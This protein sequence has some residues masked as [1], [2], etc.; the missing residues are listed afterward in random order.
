MI[1]IPATIAS[2]AKPVVTVEES[3]TLR[4]GKSPV[5]IN[6]RPSKSI[7][8]SLPA[9][10]F[11]A[12]MFLLLKSN[13]KL[14]NLV[15]YWFEEIEHGAQDKS[16]LMKEDR[17]GSRPYGTYKSYILDCLLLLPSASCLLP[18]AVRL[19]PSVIQSQLLMLGQRLWRSWL[20]SRHRSMGKCSSRRE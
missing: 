15:V 8:K 6:Q 18:P 20:S 9:K 10:I 2:T 11:F 13:N 4:K 1:N 17:K 12:D 19:L 16:K 3:L 5:R 14:F 7:P